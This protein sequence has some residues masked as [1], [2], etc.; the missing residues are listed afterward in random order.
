MFPIIPKQRDLNGSLFVACVFFGVVGA[1]HAQQIGERV[2]SAFNDIEHI[3]D[4]VLISNIAV[5]GTTIECGLFIKPPLVIQP[6]TPFQAGGN[7]LQRMTISLVNRTNKTIAFGDI[8]LHFLDT[9]DCRSAPCV[10]AE[11]RFGQMPAIDAYEGRTGRPIKPE[12]PER[13]PLDWKPQQTLVV[14][15]S[16]YM[17]EIEQDL[18][19]YGLPVTAVS[20]VN[21]YRGV[22]FFADG[23]RWTLGAYGVPDPEHPGKFKELPAEY[24]PGDRGNNWPPGYNQ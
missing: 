8:H 17:P 9:G 21:V 2:V 12:Y 20:K 7:W 3:Q 15:V 4:A 5:D 14:H 13:P 6:V 22:F 23:M 19:A 24:F 1:V 18:A 11:L 10:G 16:D